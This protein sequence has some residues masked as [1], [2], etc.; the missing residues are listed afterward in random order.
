[1]INLLVRREVYSPNSTIG[2]LFLNGG[3]FSYTLEPR[4]SQT[5]GKPFAIPNGIYKVI[6]QMSDKFRTVTPHLQ[7]VPGFDAI[8]IH[9]GNYPNDTAG[10]LMVGAQKGTDFI[11]VS[12]ATFDNLMR[13]ISDVAL[14]EPTVPSDPEGIMIAYVG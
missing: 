6:L 14:G 1:M 9:W 5:E 12:R 3:F 10:C 2:E 8:E 13:Q 7:D 4:K 11:G